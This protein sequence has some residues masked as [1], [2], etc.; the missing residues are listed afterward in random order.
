MMRML[1]E[2]K[3]LKIIGMMKRK[4]LLQDLKGK[5][6]SHKYQRRNHLASKKQRKK[7]KNRLRPKHT[8]RTS[9]DP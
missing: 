6:T 1:V 7:N 3:I 8:L 4:S 5:R 9:Q 2:V